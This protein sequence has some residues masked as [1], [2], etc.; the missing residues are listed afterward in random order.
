MGSVSNPKPSSN[1]KNTSITKQETSVDN[2][3][4]EEI[5]TEEN[6]LREERKRKVKDDVNAMKRT[7]KSSENKD[8]Y[9]AFQEKVTNILD[10]QE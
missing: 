6:N 2:E 7:M 10:E 8:E 5:D 1:S 3:I 9:F 4:M